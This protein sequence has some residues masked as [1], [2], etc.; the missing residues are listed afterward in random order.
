VLGWEHTFTHQVRD[1]VVAIAEDA[2]PEP[3]FDDGLR[4]Q[5]I[6]EAVA[7]SADNQT[8]WTAVD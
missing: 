7:E 6:L 5:R 3:S 8:R 2:D 4:V 1:L